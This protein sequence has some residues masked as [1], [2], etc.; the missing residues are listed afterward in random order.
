MEEKFDLNFRQIHMDF[1]TSEAIPDIAQQFNPEDFA[2]TL[3]NA[4]VNSITCFARCHHGWRYYLS[5]YIPT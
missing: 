4:H 3:K 2:K 5:W 1:H